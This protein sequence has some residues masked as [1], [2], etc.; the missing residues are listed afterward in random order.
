[1]THVMMRNDWQRMHAHLHILFM[2]TRFSSID[3]YFHR[4]SLWVDIS[5]S[6][7]PLF[8]LIITMH[9]LYKLFQSLTI[10]I[11]LSKCRL[12]RWSWRCCPVSSWCQRHIS[13]RQ[14]SQ[15]SMT[16]LGIASLARV[17]WVAPVQCWRHSSMAYQISQPTWRTM[18]PSRKSTFEL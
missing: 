14:Q 15:Q 5:I 3:R 9:E 2:S 8:H 7:L 4:L 16:G 10:S 18:S 1:M 17:H 11:H 6:S 13:L 12:H